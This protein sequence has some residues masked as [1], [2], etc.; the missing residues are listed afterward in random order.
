MRDMFTDEELEQSAEQREAER[1]AAYDACAKAIQ[2][3]R[4]WGWTNIITHITLWFVG[5]KY[6]L[7]MKLWP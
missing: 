1:Q 2:S 3:Y 6:R 4:W 7:G 5:V